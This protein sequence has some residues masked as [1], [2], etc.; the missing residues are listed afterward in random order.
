MNSQMILESLRGTRLL[1]IVR[2]HS[3]LHAE[4]IV[5]TLIESGIDSIEISLTTPR[6]TEIV[7]SFARNRKG[8]FVGAG[9]VLTASETNAV[10]EAG[11]Q[12]IVTPA[13]SESLDEAV[14]LGIP[15]F[16]GVM[17]PTEAVEAMRRGASALKLFPAEFGGPGLLKALRAPLPLYDFVP[18][19]GV[20][21]NLVPDYLDAGALALGVGSP[22]SGSANTAPDLGLIRARAADYRAAIA[23]WNDK[24]EHAR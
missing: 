6:A 19:G 23:A 4:R 14:L 21:L 9:T 8:T 2:N 16:T 3:T 7:A 13:I 18:V 15:S 5:E 20:T 11:A 1:A 10:T 24:N 22:L 12:F 17:T